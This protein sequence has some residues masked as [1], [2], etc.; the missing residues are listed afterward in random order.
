MDV[1]LKGVHDM[2]D[3]TEVGV[4]TVD[5]FGIV[6]ASIDAARIARNLD[7]VHGRLGNVISEPALKYGVAHLVLDR[8]SSWVLLIQLHKAGEYWYGR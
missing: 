5:D 3:Y 7:T 8:M 4:R 2:Y 6:G 1:A